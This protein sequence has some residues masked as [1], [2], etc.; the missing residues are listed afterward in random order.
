MSASLFC[1]FFDR[2]MA[3]ENDVVVLVVGEHPA[4]KAKKVYEHLVKFEPRL[5][6]YILRAYSPELNPAS[7]SSGGTR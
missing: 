4:H 3:G 1:E 5:P 7:S 2:L 6:F